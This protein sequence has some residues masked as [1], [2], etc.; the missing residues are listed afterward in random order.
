MSSTNHTS[1]DLSSLAAE[2]KDRVWRALEAAEMQKKTGTKTEL[3]LGFATFF[4]FAHNEKQ[5]ILISFLDTFSE[6]GFESFLAKLDSLYTNSERPFA[7]ILDLRAIGVPPHPWYVTRQAEFLREHAQDMDRC[8]EWSVIVTSSELI[9]S[10]VRMLFQ[11]VP[12]RKPMS[13]ISISSK[14][15]EAPF[16]AGSACSA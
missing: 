2:T 15:V 1:L 16:Y 6:E 7:L 14:F 10:V 3:E 8:V 13:I 12:P 9:A 4:S 11:I 5:T